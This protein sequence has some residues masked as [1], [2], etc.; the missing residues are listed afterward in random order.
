MISEMAME[1]IEDLASHGTVLT[2]REIVRL[3]ALGVKAEHN[4]DSYSFYALPRCVFLGDDVVLR[5][6]T[7]GHEI[8]YD[9][10]SRRFNID[11]ELTDF[12]LR[13]FMM[14][15]DSDKLPQWDNIKQ[16][17]TTLQDFIKNKLKRY[18]LRQLICCVDYCINGNDPSNLEYPFVRQQ[19][20]QTEED[21][22]LD[23]SIAVG[24][25][26]DL[27]MVGLG[28]P[29]KDIYTMT[30]STIQHIVQNKYAEKGIDVEKKIKDKAIGDYYST[31][32]EIKKQHLKEESDVG[33]T[34]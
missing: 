12:C 10:I 32:N 19:E 15:M 11:D 23:I 18:T 13:A 34:H 17:T 30:R 29:L 16:V 7:V 9:M 27:Q 6:P 28:I 3:N 2:P 4:S 20:D 25:V 22:D 24:A 33:E 1:D 8:W 14:S 31:L 5:E 26:R 21:E